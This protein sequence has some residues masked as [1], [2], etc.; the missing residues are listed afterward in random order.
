MVSAGRFARR[1]AHRARAAVRVAIWLGCVSAVGLAVALPAFAARARRVAVETGRDLALVAAGTS[2]SG[3]TRLRLNGEALAMSSGISDEPPRVV[4]DRLER[5]CSDHAGGLAAAFADL[6]RALGAHTDLSRVGAPGIGVVREGGDD[7][8]LVLCF[9]GEGSPWQRLAAFG[10]SGD[11]EDLGGVRAAI[12]RRGPTA[13][14]HVVALWSDGPFDLKKV[15]DGEPPPTEAAD[16]PAPEGTRRRLL[17]T[18]DGAPYA[19]R[20][21]EGRVDLARHRAALARLGWSSDRQ[22]PHAFFKDDAE[23]IVA[24]SER[25]GRPFVSVAELRRVP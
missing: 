19:V 18:V 10:S 23:A 4:L 21:Y 12:V 16:L 14:S 7:G 3:V 5:A 22:A 25:D 15:L 20:I 13:A 6:D 11:L 9:A 8:G 2:I 1:A 17:I 24:I